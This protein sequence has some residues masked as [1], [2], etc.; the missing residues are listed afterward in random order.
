MDV[1]FHI[2]LY[3]NLLNGKSQKLADYIFSTQSLRKGLNSSS[4]LLQILCI[5]NPQLIYPCLPG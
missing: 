2:S 5:I 1:L 3:L 4:F